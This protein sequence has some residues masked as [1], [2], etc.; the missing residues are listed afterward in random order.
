MQKLYTPA[1]ESLS[2]IPWN[3]Y[4]RPQMVR[5][6]W[7]CL[8]G[9][10][11]F[12]YDGTR[13]QITVPFCPES[14]LSGLAIRMKYGR[15]MKYTRRFSLP[16]AWRGRRTLL[17]FGAVNRLAS[18]R[19]NGREAAVHEVGYLPFTA[20]ITAF[21]RDGE[22][23]LSVTAVNDLSHR[24]PWGKQKEKRGGMWYTPV[25]GIWKTVWLEPVPPQYIRALTV[26]TDGSTAEILAEGPETGTA[27]GRRF[28]ARLPIS[29]SK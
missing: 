13:T 22:N 20:D 12:E 21:L 7:L 2:G 24:Y 19:V 9:I 23:E 5:K 28:P 6:D 27:R 15:E 17:Q 29:D 14:L 26:T 18:V 4:P 8:N 10:W 3:T 11:D 25:S 1:G 16:E